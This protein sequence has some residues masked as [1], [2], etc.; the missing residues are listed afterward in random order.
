[1]ERNSK[2][3]SSVADPLKFWSGSGSAEPYLWLMEPDP[4]KFVSDLQRES[5]RQQKKFFCLLLCEVTFTKSF[6]DKKS[7]RSHKTVEIKVY[8][9]FFACWWNYPDAD[10]EGPKT[11]IWIRTTSLDYPHLLQAEWPGLHIPAVTLNLLHVSAV[12]V[13]HFCFLLFNFQYVKKSLLIST[14]H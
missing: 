4:A 5:R 10:P 11:W 14:S 3:A 7:W 2:D 13:V 12:P 9:Y 6:E 8:L 1:V